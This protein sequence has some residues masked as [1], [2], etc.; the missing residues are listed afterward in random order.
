M[1]SPGNMI[2][3]PIMIPTMNR[4]QHL[5]RAIESLRKNLWA[6]YTDIYIGVDFPPSAKYFEGYNRII[7]YLNGDF[8]E[9][10]SFN[11]VKRDYNYGSLQNIASLRNMI[12]K[13]YDR[14]IKADDD[15][16]FSPNFIEYM[17]KCLMEYENDSQ[18]IA[19]TGYS[20]PLKWV[21]SAGST[22]FFENF[23][24]PMW[25]IGLWRDKFLTIN[26]YIVNQKGL[27]QDSRKIVL[28]GCLSRM[29][30]AC[31]KEFA[32]LCLTPDFHV[33]LASRFT[34]ISLRM[35]MSVYDK[36]VVMPVVSKV[37]NWGF[38]GSG[39]FCA[40]VGDQVKRLLVA[41]DYQY[42]FQPIEEK[43]DF[44][45]VK[46]SIRSINSNRDLMNKFDPISFFA[47]LKVNI[48]LILF[49]LFGKT[50]FM[51]ITYLI[52]QIKEF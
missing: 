46:D 41:K 7:E 45:L 1:T 35:Y 31:R 38:D 19:V 12:F 25:G 23:I 11:V 34:D 48:K 39:E 28:S 3:A 52:R 13:N 30:D 5:K 9:F 43:E 36:R 14:L 24:C 29:T 20:Y 17:D 18:T 10:K 37:R 22:V 50:N 16:E 42:Q 6:K 32:D 21:V 49:V 15:A 33:T 4:Y 51:R 44:V 8:S 40:A 2:Y 27:G 47:K 26:D